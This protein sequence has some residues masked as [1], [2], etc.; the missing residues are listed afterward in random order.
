MYIYVNSKTLESTLT[1]ANRHRSKPTVGAI[2]DK[3]YRK[4]RSRWQY[5]LYSKQSKKRLAQQ[6]DTVLAWTVNM[7]LEVDI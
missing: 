5:N 7:L 2:C 3:I 1:S 4:E 6:K